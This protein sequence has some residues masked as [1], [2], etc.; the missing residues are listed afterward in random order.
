VLGLI[1]AEIA[2]FAFEQVA[3]VQMVEPGDQ[4]RAAD[5]EAEGTVELAM[6]QIGGDVGCAG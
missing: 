4:D 6:R 2:P 5:G 3:A 1:L